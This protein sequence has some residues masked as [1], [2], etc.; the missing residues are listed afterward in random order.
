MHYVPYMA[1]DL[2]EYLYDFLYFDVRAKEFD[3]AKKQV[4]T[5]VSEYK[6]AFKLTAFRRH[7]P[8]KVGCNLIR[9]TLK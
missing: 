9:L 2:L 3:K 7:Y 5:R 6:Q 8:P 4:P 1:S